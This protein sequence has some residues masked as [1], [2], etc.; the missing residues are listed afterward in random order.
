ML[1]PRPHALTA[2]KATTG[3]LF[4]PSTNS[5]TLR[6]AYRTGSAA[7]THT[8]TLLGEDSWLARGARYRP[9]DPRLTQRGRNTVKGK[10]QLPYLLAHRSKHRMV[11]STYT[12]TQTGQER[13]LRESGAGRRPLTLL[14]GLQ[15]PPASAR[16][17]LRS[18]SHQLLS[19]QK[20]PSPL[21]RSSGRVFLPL[22]SQTRPFYWPIRHNIS[23]WSQTLAIFTTST[24]KLAF[25]I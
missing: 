6:T 17:T 14:T 20:P 19:R 7:H 4:L 8:G 18:P 16:L 10:A 12:T 11:H 25:P 3:T 23:T 21:C 1:A 2:S 22:P 13:V 9:T 15:L 24:P 5:V